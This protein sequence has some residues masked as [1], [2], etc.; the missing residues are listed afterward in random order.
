RELAGDLD[1]VYAHHRERGM[2][3][4]DAQRRAEQSVLGTTHVIRRLS[5]L[6]RR[7][8][9]GWS[10]SMAAR[11]SSGIELLMLG[12][13][14]VPILAAAALFA[15]RSAAGPIAWLTS[16]V[17]IGI[18]AGIALGVIRTMRGQ[19]VPSGLLE[20]LL[21][22]GVVACALGLLGAAYGL[23]ATFASLAAGTLSSSSHVADLTGPL[24]REGSV[25]VLG[26]L[27][28]LA[29]L[30]AWFLLLGR[31][32]ARLSAEVEALLGPEEPIRAGGANVIPLE[33]GRSA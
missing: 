7:S 2:D 29:A 24:V 20:A 26:L 31:E 11:L 28:A 5:R 17:G 23:H 32:A 33:T 14:V 19:E 27:L 4:A 10:E 30:F 6:H 12:L 22:C 18:A 15:V 13:G 21:V 3:E 9:R 1:A 16:L 8:W 25:L